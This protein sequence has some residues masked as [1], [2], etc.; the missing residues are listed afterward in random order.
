MVACRKLKQWNMHLISQQVQDKAVAVI[1][2]LNP[3]LVMWRRQAITVVPSCTGL[4]WG[5]G[6][7]NSFL[8]ENSLLRRQKKVEQ[9]LRE[10]SL[11]IVMVKCLGLNKNLHYRCV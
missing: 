9:H 7:V 3:C 1:G 11:N 2:E 10:T 5:L 6:M 8:A 4:R